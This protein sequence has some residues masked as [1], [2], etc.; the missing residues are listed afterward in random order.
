[1]VLSQWLVLLLFVFCQKTQAEVFLFMD[2][3]GSI[4]ADFEG[5]Q[6]PN[7]GFESQEGLVGAWNTPY[8]LY[9]IESTFH[10]VF[11]DVAE[12]GPEKIAV[13]HRDYYLIKFDLSPKEGVVGSQRL[14]TAFDATTEV[15]RGETQVVSSFVPGFYRLIPP[16]SYKN[17]RFPKWSPSGDLAQN[18]LVGNYLAAK[19]KAKHNPD[20]ALF[21]YGYSLLKHFLDSEAGAVGTRILT[22]RGGHPLVWDQF[23]HFLKDHERL[24]QHAPELSDPKKPKGYIPLSSKEMLSRFG[25]TVGLLK[26]GPVLQLAE[27]RMRSNPTSVTLAPSG[28]RKIPMHTF[29]FADDNDKMLLKVQSETRKLAMSQR[30]PIKFVLINLAPQDKLHRVEWMAKDVTTGEVIENPRAVV[31]MEN[32]SL[33]LAQREEIFIPHGELLQANSNILSGRKVREDLARRQ[34]EEKL[35]VDHSSCEGVLL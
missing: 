15:G 25:D 21:G 16:H 34:L 32:G 9:R 33:R 23:F 31:I 10:P 20:Y 3:D 19:I 29:I 17:F 5:P 13:S 7:L 26:S 22:A 14:Y 28:L 12:A 8:I 1:M 18:S 35:S 4:F 30:F 11:G 2:F 6:E 24:F 27:Q